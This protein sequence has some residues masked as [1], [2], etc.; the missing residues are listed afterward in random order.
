MRILPI[1][2][3]PMPAARQCRPVCSAS[4]APVSALEH[5]AEHLRPEL[6]ER[7]GA[8]LEGAELVRIAAVEQLRG[9]VHRLAERLVVRVPPEVPRARR[10]PGDE[11]DVHAL[12]EAEL[13]V[14]TADAR[15]LH[16][17]PRAL[18]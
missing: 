2:L 11:L 5:V 9:R 10:L 13:G 1:T 3:S 12:V 17:A 7:D 14:R 4:R 6:G 8:A 18:A 15:V 16:A